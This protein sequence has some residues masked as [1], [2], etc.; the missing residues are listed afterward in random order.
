MCSIYNS[1]STERFDEN[2]FIE[3]YGFYASDDVCNREFK[4][5][6]L[7]IPKL[8]RYQ[9][10]GH[11]KVLAGCKNNVNKFFLIDVGGSCGQTA[12]NARD[13]FN[14]LTYDDAITLEQLRDELVVKKWVEVRDVSEL[15]NGIVQQTVQ[16]CGP[17][18]EN[19]NT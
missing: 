2:E 6:P 1:E 11:F 9:G 17:H 13:A 16:I 8:I 12:V 4:D 10:M 19:V 7:I 15:D 3:K 5:N 14:K 18:K